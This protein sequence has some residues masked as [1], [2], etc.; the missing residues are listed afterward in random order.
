MEKDTLI[1]SLEGEVSLD[2]FS[3]T[4]RR[5]NTLVT[6]LSEEVAKNNKIDWQIEEL[7]AGSATAAV[8]GVCEDMIFVERT[9]D[10]YEIMGSNMEKGEEI[11]YPKAISDKAKAITK[12]LNGKVTAIQFSTI[13]KDNYIT[14]ASLKGEKAKSIKYS[15]GSIRGIVESLTMRS[16]LY[17]TLWDSLFDKAV[18]C[19]YS[20][21][22]EETMREIWGKRVEVSG[23][24]GRN[25]ENGYPI[26]IRDISKVKLLPNVEPGS[27][28]NAR[29]VIPWTIGDEK[30]VSLSPLSLKEAL[31]GL[32][33]T[34]QPNDKK[35]NEKDNKPCNNKS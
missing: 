6:A 3:I 21:G 8:R 4:M 29:G 9:V 15:L 10:A 17:F 2:D 25:P 11:P 34:T 35:V 12:I 26:T 28:R 31:E 32:L 30:P 23:R 13:N 27:Y 7:S 14:S 5:F 22:E 16:R 18:K 19:Y 1:I 20:E 24:I 33:S